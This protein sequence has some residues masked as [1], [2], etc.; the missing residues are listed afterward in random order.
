MRKVLV[1]VL[2]VVCW[3]GF[4]WWQTE[5]PNEESEFGSPW[6]SAA[7]DVSTRSPSNGVGCLAEAYALVDT[8]E[9]NQ[10]STKLTV[11]CGGRWGFD[12]DME[13]LL[14]SHKKA[15]ERAEEAA[16]SPYVE[17]PPTV[18]LLSPTLDV[19]RHQMLT[20]LLVLKARR[21][22]GHGDGDAAAEE[23]L[24]ALLLNEAL[25]GREG[26][27]DCYSAGL[28]GC[29]LATA[30][31]GDVVQNED[32]SKRTLLKIADH[33]ATIEE[34]LLPS[35]AALEREKNLVTATL[36]NAE[37]NHAVQDA[38]SRF[39]PEELE[40]IA[41][42]QGGVCAYEGSLVAT[43][44]QMIA[45]AKKS[46]AQ[47]RW[48]SVV[49]TR[50]IMPYTIS[51]RRAA[52]LVT[53]ADVLLARVRLLR[54]LSL[55]A[56][57]ENPE[58]PMDPFS[59]KPLLFG[60]CCLYSVGPDGIDQAGEISYGAN[61][62]PSGSGDIVVPIIYDYWVCLSVLSTTPNSS[63]WARTTAAGPVTRIYMGP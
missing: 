25:I 26:T 11:A 39:Y 49:Q 24:W 7:V 30:A 45:E 14:D 40:F 16:R 31:L 13:G 58:M 37:A 4:L 51:S 22:A 35:A 44:D 56:V 23:L 2:L 21:L 9:I 32:V 19:S 18:D 46:P 52:S 59:G 29:N 10:L 50:G 48:E 12:R 27:L 6:T 1:F 60:A 53:N 17:L 3:V 54:A 57:G 38:F 20:K 34:I 42:R 8:N 33:T 36:R 61:G 55:M 28:A 5:H 41:N 62:S 47:R 15:I 43:W 63:R